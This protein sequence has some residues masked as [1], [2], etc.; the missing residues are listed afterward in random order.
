[1]TESASGLLAVMHIFSY[2]QNKIL[3]RLIVAPESLL[4]LI[5]VKLRFRHL[6]VV[7]VQWRDGKEMYKKAWWR[8]E[9]NPKIGC[10]TVE[11]SHRGKGPALP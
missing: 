2:Y 7:I 6:P 11:L 1:M 4:I 3:I 10:D 9:L 8:L 5:I